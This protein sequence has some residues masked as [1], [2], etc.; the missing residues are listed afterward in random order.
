MGVLGRRFVRLV[1]VG[2]VVVLGIDGELAAPRRVV[3][4]VLFVVAV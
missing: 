4:L 3:A 1:V 2:I